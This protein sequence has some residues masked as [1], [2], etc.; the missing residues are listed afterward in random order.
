[1]SCI[2]ATHFSLEIFSA[3]YTNKTGVFKTGRPI[4]RAL[5]VQQKKTSNVILDVLKDLWTV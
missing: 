2:Y 1:M 3:V 5:T 4:R